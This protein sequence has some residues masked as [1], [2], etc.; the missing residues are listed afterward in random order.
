VEALHKA[1]ARLDSPAVIQDLAG[2]AVT[3]LTRAI[4]V[5]KGSPEV[6]DRAV[7]RE[8]RANTL[9]VVL[10]RAERRAA[11]SQVKNCLTFLLQRPLWAQEARRD[12][13]LRGDLVAFLREE[14]C[15]EALCRSLEAEAGAEVPEPEPPPPE[16]SGPDAAAAASAAEAEQRVTKEYLH[17][18][19][20]ALVE[21]DFKYPTDTASEMRAADVGIGGFGQIVKG[22]QRVSQ[23]FDLVGASEEHSVEVG[24]RRSLAASAE[25]HKGILEEYEAVWPRTVGFLATLYEVRSVER[26]RVEFVVRQLTRFS[27]SFAAACAARADLPWASELPRAPAEAPPGAGAAPAGEEAEAERVA[28]AERKAADPTPP[29]LSEGTTP[30]RPGATYFVLWVDKDP[31]AYAES[32]VEVFTREGMKVKGIHDDF[33]TDP[34]KCVREAMAFAKGILSSSDE[35]LVAVIHSR[36]ETHCSLHRQIREFCSTNGKRVPFFA[37]CTRA[38][39]KEFEDNGCKMNICDKDRDAVK[40]AVVADFNRRRSLA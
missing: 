27:P 35:E 8:D 31:K 24:R 18:G 7:Q 38:E 5:C 28:E 11:K 22:I 15:E 1:I 30:L 9:R 12:E 14:E 26:E 23:K 3:K 13:K 40:G 36:G 4:N 25:S 37:A 21:V 29:M 32:M 33:E 39:P 34:E 2:E 16:V 19:Y 17:N 6:L 20:L 10:K